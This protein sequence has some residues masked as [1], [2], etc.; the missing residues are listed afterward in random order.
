M[1]VS[2]L[3]I[4]ETFTTLADLL[5]ME[6]ANPFRV[7]AYR[8]AAR[9]IAALPRA[10]AEMVER[11]ED[12]G[13]LPGIGRD[14]AGKI[15][16]LVRT[17]RLA[18]L[19]EVK[20]RTPE[21]L[22]ALLALPSLGPKRV[23][24]L[25]QALGIETVAD[26]SAALAAGRLAGLR[27]FGPTLIERLKSEVA[28]QAKAQRR[29]K[30]AEVE[31]MAEPLLAHLRAL[32]GVVRVSAAGS[33]RR[34][35]DTV[36]D[37]DI[38]VTA[39]RGVPV[40]ERLLGYEDVA[41]VVARGP[42]RATVRLRSG[43]QVDLRL[44]PDAS[45][46][47]ALVYF[48]GSKAHNIA[49]RRIGVKR[50]LKINEYGVFRGDR[51]IA[52]RTEAE[53]YARIGL[54]V[55]PPELREDRGE[56]EAARDG[57]L[58]ELVERAHIR[59]DLHVHTSASDG[60]LSLAEMAQAARARGYEYLA[61][62][63]HSRRV[64]VAHG[65]DARRL[66]AQIDAIDRL[67]ERLDGLTLLKSVEVDILEDGSLDLPDDI[68]RRLDFT[69]CSIHYRLALPADRQTERIIRAMD[70]P[71][72][73]ILGHPTGRLIGQRE[74]SALD[75]DRI[76]AGARERGCFLEVN[77]QPDRLD[78]SDTHCRL[79]REMG[80]KVAI[81]TDAHSDAE[82]DFMR[83]GVDQARRGWLGPADVLNTRPLAELRRLLRR[84]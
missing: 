7:R 54:P 41:A 44:V 57:T 40:M 83:F 30:L 53:V 19:E 47:A 73:T 28:R 60:R 14:L 84:R 80:V 61:I 75:M 31:Q 29:F 16:E 8:T 21:S 1:G 2:N 52:G 4:A 51:R 58:P 59:G 11:G 22:T 20:A 79:A 10:V 68:L 49:I 27:G 46:G 33:Y 3:H 34:R 26:L 72:F 76:V 69:V 63:D 23:E 67:N 25:H 17:G 12:L 37:L 65:L 35:R 9:T 45:Y 50:G 15:A 55:I 70:N 78:L 64:T 56:V 39:R 36:G 71:C 32:P 74:P 81:S 6:G 5:E 66:A 48:T 82:L 13:E 24:R 62:S 77:A 38:V 42:T 18:L 43:L